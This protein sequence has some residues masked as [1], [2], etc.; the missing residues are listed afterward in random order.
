MFRWPPSKNVGIYLGRIS[1]CI[2]LDNNLTGMHG[3]NNTVNP[4]TV[5]F[6]GYT[7]LFCI[8][9]VWPWKGFIVAYCTK[10]TW[11]H[12]K[13]AVKTGSIQRTWSR[14]RSNESHSKGSRFKTRPIDW[15][16][17]LKCF[18]VF[19]QFF[20]ANIVIASQIRSRPRPFTTLSI[21]NSL[22]I[23]AVAAATAAGD[24]DNNN[25][26]FTPRGGAVGWDTALQAGRSLVR[27]PMVPLD[28]FIYIILLAALWP[29]GW[30]SL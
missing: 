23:H 21:Q 17:W 28:F 4:T 9:S 1:M 22:I 16:S 12:W 19:P 7:N 8:L 14:T 11:S 20:Q 13:V 26:N 10:N 24:D 29:W 5:V 30:L 6:D 15:L 2:V 18:R 3:T 27:F 25:D